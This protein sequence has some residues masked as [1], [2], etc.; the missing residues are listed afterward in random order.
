MHIEKQVKNKL[1]SKYQTFKISTPQNKIKNPPLGQ[2]SGKKAVN[3]A[4]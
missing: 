1:L 2:Q 3:N 4:S